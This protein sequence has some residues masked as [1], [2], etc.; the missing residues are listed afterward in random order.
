M[1]RFSDAGKDDLTTRYDGR[2]PEKRQ[3][4]KSREVGRG[5]AAGYGDFAFR[6]GLNRRGVAVAA[7]RSVSKR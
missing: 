2:R 1:C 7:L 3:G 6:F 5:R 4:T